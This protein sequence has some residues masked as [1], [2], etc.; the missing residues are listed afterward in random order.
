[1]ILYEGDVLR[2]PFR[3]MIQRPLPQ[4]DPYALQSKVTQSSFNQF[5]FKMR[6]MLRLQLLT[7]KVI[8]VILIASSFLLILDKIVNDMNDIEDSYVF[9]WLRS[10]IL[11]SV[12]LIIMTQK[13]M[14][15]RL[16][17]FLNKENADFWSSKGVTCRL[18]RW[19][20]TA[21]IEFQMNSNRSSYVPPNLIS[22]KQSEP[23]QTSTDRN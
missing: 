10:A 20:R 13:M 2:V 6:N 12:A 22:R 19:G 11:A 8:T 9:M 4:I 5:C 16:N 17:A 1:M 21:C 23:C 14:K 7:E 18:A 15:T 3:M